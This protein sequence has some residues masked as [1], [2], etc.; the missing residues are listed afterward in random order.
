MVSKEIVR[1]IPASQSVGYGEEK[2]LGSNNLGKLAYLILFWIFTWHI[3]I[4][5]ALRS[6]PEYR[7]KL[8]FV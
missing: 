3:N 4:L 6:P 8:N 2:I 5:K 1:K 7:N